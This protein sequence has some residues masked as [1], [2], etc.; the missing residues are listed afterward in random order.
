MLE[1]LN[2]KKPLLMG[3]LDI[4]PDSFS[5]G[6]K[7]F[8]TENAI[9]HAK[10]LTDQ[11]VDIIDVGGE[12]TRPDAKPVSEEEELRRVIPVVEVLEKIKRQRSR[13]AKKQRKQNSFLISIDTYK[14]NVAQLALNAGADIINDVSGLTM[15]PNMVQTARDANCQIVIMHNKGIPATKPISIEDRSGMSA[16]CPSSK[17]E[18]N[19]VQEVYHWLQKQ[20][21]YAINNGIKKENIIIDPGLG[22]GKTSEEDLYL[23]KN[24]DRFKPLGFPILI[25]PSRKSFIKKLF[26]NDDLETKS[27]ELIKLAVSNGADIVRVH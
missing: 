9:K 26:P 18:S 24:L 5:D 1:H 11:G 14:S 22:F 15:D 4:T 6:G 20:T 12:S 23:I 2:L 17:N 7:Y 8:Q 25:G 10:K 27:K 16:T 21:Q 13:E 19:I 3:V